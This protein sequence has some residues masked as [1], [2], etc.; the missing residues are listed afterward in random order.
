[1][2]TGDISIKSQLMA[3]CVILVTIPVIGLGILSY[4][5][6][7]EAILKNIKESL[8]A[9]CLD[10]FITTRA[11]YDLVEGNK[12]AALDKTKDIATSQAKGVQEL[13]S[14]NI[15]AQVDADT[16]K[17]PLLRARRYE[18]N[19]LLFS[20]AMDEF[21]A[22]V[23]E[24]D[25][26]MAEV[27]GVL[28]RA[29]KLGINT[30]A[31]D[32]ALSEYDRV[33]RIVKM[34]ERVTGGVNDKEVELAG[35]EL[36]SQFDNMI[37]QMS[38][39]QMDTQLIDL[40]ASTVVG[41]NGYIYILDYEGNYILSKNRV[42]DGENIWYAENQDG[43]FVFRD[44]IVIGK[45]LKEG[46]IGHSAYNWRDSIE[47]KENQKVVA[48]MHIP[49][50]EWIVAVAFYPQD[51]L[52]ADF[53]EIK[54]EQLK[55]LMARQKI[56]QSGYLC[57]IGAQGEKRGRYILS[58]N[59]T[60]DGQDALLDKDVQGK[61]FISEIVESASSLDP[62]ESRIISYL[63]QGRGSSSP[64]LKI[65][66]YTYFQPWDWMIA[67]VA[68]LDEFFKG[69]NNIRNQIVFVCVLA[70]VLG[71]SVAY[72][73]ASKMTDTFT[74]LADK[75]DSV[76]R[77][78][79]DVQMGDIRALE[80]K[81]EIGQL[82][83]AFRQMS[84]NLRET[85]FSKDY[86]D[87][88][89]ENMNDALLVIDKNAR[90]KTVNNATARLL[91][92]DRS[93][94]IKRPISDF[95]MAGEKDL[96]IIKKIILQGQG[97]S[98]LEIE[99]K[100]KQGRSIPVSFN[101]VP[102][103]DQEGKT[104]SAILAA[105]DVREYKRLL[106]ELSKTGKQLQEQVEKLQKSDKAMLLMVEDLNATSRDLKQAKDKLQEKIIEVERSNKEL[107]D[108]TYV[109]SHDLKEPL[110]GIASFSQFLHDKYK[111]KLDEQGK[112]YLDVIQRS[113][114]K[115]Q[116]LIKDLLELSRIARRRASLEEIDLNRLIDE[117][118][119]DLTV[120]LKESNTELKAQK[121]PTI[122]FEK[123]R[124]SQLF[125]N[126]ITNAIKYNDKPKPMIEIGCKE[127]SPAE[128]C[129]YVRDNGQGIPKE[130]LDTVF[131]LFQRLDTDEDK[132]T[133]AG[134]T[135]CKKI[136]EQHGG[137]IWVESEVGKGSTFYFTILKKQKQ[138]KSA[139][140]V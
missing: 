53:E 84:A 130:H 18:K 94:I 126:L 10:W 55:D 39:R 137:R 63:Y 114:Q 57:L 36:E 101:G 112:H 129:L 25:L 91:E 111:D 40:L 29:K 78:R 134:L 5:S 102:F 89:I 20:F 1:M 119:E 24:F 43:K 127:D 82:A 47:D 59:R 38:S 60:R 77:G 117:I 35:S 123:V 34:R 121:L 48:I 62:G 98:N 23:K 109:V 66:A 135:I 88:I 80:T 128:F 85:T 37:N 72:I 75:M 28:E 68:Y 58:E 2:K 99:L 3:I 67:A 44:V 71:S 107:D 103:K 16:L 4:N 140:S 132:G 30:E 21:S 73:F 76:A 131:G 46:E 95:F 108:F 116:T 50:K 90:I 92:Y 93:E 17:E 41:Q 70:I 74:Q 113:V 139:E 118:R 9:Q 120:R 122:K 54:K 14:K 79:L 56:G 32:K 6:A 12:D 96:A 97:V 65:L 45:S 110:R 19:M 26:A 7:K 51:L 8:K 81:N 61:L 42:R 125:T 133:G 100:D 124:I 13:I 49:Q 105:R 86:V 115:M 138:K 83:N 87:N 22:Y 27:S 106:E 104:T 69:V 52:A 64:R 11:Y 15:G 33:M 31:V 136:V